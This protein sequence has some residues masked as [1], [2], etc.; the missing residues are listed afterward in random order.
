MK[1]VFER[2]MR[3]LRPQK[4]R[5]IYV[6]AIAYLP[7]L[8]LTMAF[9]NAFG[10]A[11]AKVTITGSVTDS[12]GAAIINAN[13]TAI[14]KISVGTST[15]ANGKFVLDV[16]PGTVLAISYI[17]FAEQRITVKAGVTTY[18]IELRPAVTNAGDEV[19]VVAFSQKQ[20]KEAIVGSVTSVNPEELKIPAS[21]LTNA[22]AGQVAGLVSFQRSGQPG[23][24]NASFFIRG[25]T[26]FGYNSSPLILIDNVELSASDLARLQV[27][28][29]ASFS[30]LKDASATALYGARGANGVILVSTKEGKVGKAKINA[31]VEQSS[32][33]NTQTLKLADPITYMRLYNEATVTRDPLSPLP[34][35]QNKIQNTQATVDKAPGSNEYVYPAVD[36]LDMLFK[37]RTSTQ[38]A[39]LSLSGGGGVA[40]YYVAGSYNLDNGIIKEDTRN[41]VNSNVKFQNYQL[42]SNVNIDVTKSTELIVRLSANFSDYN[43]PLVTDG[44][45]S[46]NLY[47]VAMHTSPVLFPAF[48]PADSANLQTKHILFGNVPTQNPNGL[49]YNNPY[50]L[51]LRGHKNSSESR[52]SAQLELNQKLNFITQGLNFRAIFSTNRYSFFESQMGSSPFYYNATNY[53][54]RTNLYNLNWINSQPTGNNVAQEYLSYYPGGTNLNTFLYFMG[55]LNYNRK[56]G[57]H[58]VSASLIATGQQTRYSNAG[59]LQASLPYRNQT[60]A[61]RATYSFL[62]RYFAEFNFGYNGSERFSSNHRYGFFPTIGAGW[63]VSNEKFWDNLSSVFTRMKL[64]GSYG[65]SG[66]DNI[67]S[68]RFFYISDVNLNGGGNYANFG[69]NNGYGRSGVFINNYENPDVTWETAN[70]TNL[71]IE[72]TLFKKLNIIAEVYKKHTYNI[73]QNR[74]SVPATLGLEAPITANVGAVDARGLDLHFD[75]KGNISKDWWFSA[76]GNFTFAQNKYSKFEEPQWAEKYRSQIGQ[77]VNRAWGYVAERLFVDDKEALNSPTQIFSTNGKA[78]RGGDIKYRDLNEDGKIDGADQTYLG[79]PQVP[80]IT[81]GFGFSTGFK[82]FDLSGFFQGNARVSFFISPSNTSPFIPSENASIGGNAQ[83]ITA[84]AESHWSEENQNLYAQYPRLAVTRADME[85]N[86]QN[87]TWWMRDATFMRLKSLDFGYTIPARILK[88]IKLTNCRIYFNGLNLVTWSPFKLWDPEQGGNGFAYPIQKVYNIGL[89]INL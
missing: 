79:F 65:L 87:S 44:G 59:N 83:L 81:Y 25:V 26:T 88:R 31:R 4:P 76:L 49:Q 69:V 80:E 3:L 20:R 86:L 10:Q 46:T 75:Y 18:K 48:Y 37:K 21:N 6:R 85:N 55:N 17:G 15:D 84:F 60:L 61:G 13:I 29:I 64:R 14:G 40:R 70:Q 7:L 32:S 74:S 67:S 72:M 78:P 23:Q 36:W 68:R 54:K 9:G 12:A 5:L 39:N 58:N 24:D 28:D 63:V 53:D 22:L 16:A 38:R 42:R 2:L 19:V 66:N 8:L 43:G 50:A 71:A 33:Q 1:D 77:P 35:N 73:L 34:F 41:G 62:D 51:L 30:F 45:F 47:D 11:P 57:D 27:D 89:N 56:F 52:M 82:G